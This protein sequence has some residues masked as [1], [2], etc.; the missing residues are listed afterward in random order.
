MD[1]LCL[2]QNVSLIGLFPL[3]SF[4]YLFTYSSYQ[5]STKDKQQRK[6][7]NEKKNTSYGPGDFT[8]L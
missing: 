6:I 1:I 2:Q 8:N 3:F 5:L 4:S 7:I